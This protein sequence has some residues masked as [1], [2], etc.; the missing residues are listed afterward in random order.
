MPATSSLAAQQVTEHLC[1]S[2]TMLS[3]SDL[4]VRFGERRSG[5]HQVG[6]ESVAWCPSRLPNL[7]AWMSKRIAATTHLAI[8]IACKKE[9]TLEELVHQLQSSGHKLSAHMETLVLTRTCRC[10]CQ[11]HCRWWAWDGTDCPIPTGVTLAQLQEHVMSLCPKVHTMSLW[12][13]KAPTWQVH[14]PSLRH[15]CLRIPPSTSIELKYIEDGPYA[16]HLYDLVEMSGMQD[17]NLPHLQTLFL[18]GLRE[19]TEVRGIDFRKSA[20]LE[21][22]NIHDCWISDLSVPPACKIFVSAQSEFFIG[23]MDGSREHPL[24][25][26]ATH[27][28]LPTDLGAFSYK[29]DF[30]VSIEEQRQKYALGVPNMFPE[31]RSLRLT[32]PIESICCSRYRSFLKRMIYF[33]N[34]EQEES[35]CADMALYHIRCLP[36][37]WQHMNLKELIIEGKSLGVTIP[38]VPN[39]ETLLIGC[40]GSVALDFV[41]ADSLGYTITTMSVTGEYIHFDRQQHRELSLA[42]QVRDLELVGDWRSCISVR[43]CNEA[44]HPEEELQWQAKQGLACQCKAC[45]SCL[46]IGQTK[47]DEHDRLI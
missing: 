30:S 45:P 22:I 19:P 39:L 47:L 41:D 15:I 32:R 17:D 34:E 6:L 11:S 23:H 20:T 36:R 8:G 13:A 46:G 42:L 21:V 25:S 43:G 14:G 7:L 44:I 28:C 12:L 29:G 24:V 18:Q 3:A 37:H 40:I 26:K 1:A 10:G 9:C 4:G 27:V 35:W 38:A 16:K 2:R 33:P 5:L 31:M